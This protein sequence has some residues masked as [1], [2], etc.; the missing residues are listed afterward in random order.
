MFPV[1]LN[2]KGKS[3]VVF[4][5]GKVAERR[6]AKLLKANAKIRVVSKEFTHSLKRLAD[7]NRG[8]ELITLT[9]DAANAREFIRGSDFVLIATNDKDLNNTI[10]KESKAG[11]K[12]VN[13]ADGLADFSIPATL[14]LGDAI[15]SIS[16]SGKSPAVTKAIKRRI[17]K[18]ITKEDILQVELQ[19]F[20]RKR[21][22]K[23]IKDQAKRKEVLREA[24]NSP[25]ILRLLKKGAVDRAKK[26]LEETCDAYNKH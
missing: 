20:A 15:I 7:R 25:E 17:K 10:E 21:L 24:L 6:V 19:E 26:E 12:L 14:E 9:L 18:A 8:L 2:L 4:G 23:S 3:V 5:G 22:K 11:G 1:L 16:T 13:R